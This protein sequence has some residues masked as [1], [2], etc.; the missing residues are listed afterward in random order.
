MRDLRTIRGVMPHKDYPATED[1][2]V[3]RMFSAKGE[4]IRILATVGEGWDHVSVSLA[5]RCPTWEELELIKRRFF[6]DH[7]TAMQLHVP[8]AD[9]VN[10][11]EYCL[12]LW[13]P[14]EGEIPRPPAVLV[15][16]PGRTPDEVEAMKLGLFHARNF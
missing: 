16:L 2:G 12:H 6:E 5:R 3:F 9:H 8:P 11:N 1:V 4:T 7:E 13:R 15:G 14:L 10:N